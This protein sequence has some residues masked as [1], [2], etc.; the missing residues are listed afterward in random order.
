MKIIVI[1]WKDERWS[2]DEKALQGINELINKNNKMKYPIG[3]RFLI[4]V[5]WVAI[6]PLVLKECVIRGF[7]WVA[8]KIKKK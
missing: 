5:G 2:A 1:S 6:S 8:R 7:K 3:E 4:V